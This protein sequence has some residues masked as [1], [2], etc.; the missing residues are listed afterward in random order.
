MEAAKNTL[1]LEISMRAWTNIIICKC[2]KIISGQSIIESRATI[3]T[4]FSK[5][6]PLHIQPRSSKI[7]WSRNSEIFSLVRQNGR[8]VRQTWTRVIF[9]W[10]YL[11]A[12]VYNPLPKTLNNLKK[13]IEREVDKINKKNVKKGLWKFWKTL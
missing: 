6:E 8:H 13:H 5:T 9:L 10:K 1:M 2:F 3:R 4:I 11:E 7:G 12:R